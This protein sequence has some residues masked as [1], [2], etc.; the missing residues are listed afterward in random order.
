MERDANYLAVGSFVLLV[1]AM[2]ILFIYWYSSAYH[3]GNYARYEIYFNGS[4]SGLAVGGP[5]RYLGVDVGQVQAIRIDP[6]TPTLVQVV[7]GLAPNTP[8]SS[9]TVAQLSLQGITGLQ[10]IN[11]RERTPG[12]RLPLVTGSSEQY[13]VIASEQSSVD[14]VLEDLPELAA[15]LESLLDR[16]SRLLSDQNILAFNH[17]ATHMDAASADLPA[18]V[19]DL[20]GL[21]R[22]LRGTVRQ[23]NA[24]LLD[25]HRVSGTARTDAVATLQQLNVMSANLARSSARLDAFLAHSAPQMSSLV[26]DAVPQLEGLLRESRATLRQI[27]ALTQSLRHNP[28]Q[29][30]YQAHPAGVTIPP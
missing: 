1:L 2:G 25:L 9:R 13:P 27:D 30:I 28:S 5:V 20:S 10:F 3:R 29:L 19:H 18:S 8:V 16:G 24:V 14:V 22:Q 11:L 17:I 23:A 26:S 7:V 15:R 4:V 12:Q 6:R 21:I